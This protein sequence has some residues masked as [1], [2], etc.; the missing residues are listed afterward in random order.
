VSTGIATPANTI[1]APQRLRTSRPGNIWTLLPT[2]GTDLFEEYR[3][4]AYV[5]PPFSPVERE[6]VVTFITVQERETDYSLLPVDEGVEDVVVMITI[7]DGDAVVL[8]TTVIAVTTLAPVVTTSEY[9]ITLPVTTVQLTTVAPSVTGIL[10]SLA[11]L[12]VTT[13]TV[14]TVAPVIT[15]G[16]LVE[17]PL[18]VIQVTAVAPVVATTPVGINVSAITYSQSSQFSGSAL[19]SNAI[20]TDGSF[21]NTGAA[22]TIGSP[23]W[24]QMDLGGSFQV[25]KVIV[26]TGT[27]SIPGGWSKFY[28]EN[29]DTQYSA[30]GTTWTTAFNTGAFA[31]NGIYT[32][33]VS[34]TA[35]YI[36]IISRPESSFLAL[37]EFYALSP[38]QSYP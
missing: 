18:T 2:S 34:F 9:L 17:L 37:S 1:P 22:T 38:G 35:R 25:A 31:S 27:S 24:I 20:M 30:D 6:R 16:S 19:A 21:S 14:T 10:E 3:T 4:P 5:Y 28:T 8:P 11:L 12:P 26:G 7:D 13:I 32:F 33:T 15:F 29:C 36:R 23:S